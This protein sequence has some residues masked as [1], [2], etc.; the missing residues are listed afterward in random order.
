VAAL[1]LREVLDAVGRGDRDVDRLP[2]GLGEQ[3]AAD[4][5]AISRQLGYRPGKA[6]S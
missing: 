5:S 1:D 2:R 4:T 3:L 6:K